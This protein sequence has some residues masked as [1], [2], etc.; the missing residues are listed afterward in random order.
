MSALTHWSSVKDE[1]NTIAE[2]LEWL[3]ELGVSLDTD[4]LDPKVFPL[5]EDRKPTK[6]IDRFLSVDR[7][8]LEK[9]RQ[10]LLDLTRHHV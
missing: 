2:F 1:W 8:Q 5:L 7:K 3:G 6:L 10:A 9:E 4:Y